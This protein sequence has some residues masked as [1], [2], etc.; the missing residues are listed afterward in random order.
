VV[1]RAVGEQGHAERGARGE[2]LLQPPPARRDLTRIDG[3]GAPELVAV[4]R[5][6]MEHDVGTAGRSPPDDVAR[7]RVSP[8]MATP[9]DDDGQPEADGEVRK[10]GGMAE[11][12]R[13]VED[14]RRVRT[15]G[16]HRVAPGEQ[17]S[18]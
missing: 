16:A 8:A 9:D 5:E 2:S 1:I 12:V 7:R 14:G 11:R 17:V 4:G 3:K 10:R 15:Q 13:A 18:N 6:V